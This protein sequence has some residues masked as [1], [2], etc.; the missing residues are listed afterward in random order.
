M[1]VCVIERVGEREAV[2]TAVESS[3]LILTDLFLMRPSSHAVSMV[4]SLND[5]VSSSC[6][7]KPHGVKS[8]VVKS[9]G[10]KPHGVNSHSVKSRRV[11]PHVVKSRGFKSHGVKPRGVKSH[12]VKSRGV[13]S[14]G[15]RPHGVS[16]L[17]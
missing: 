4:F 12:G 1:C 5:F 6:R 10:V 9:H 3:I 8:R 17:S 14:H 11:K 16:P 7:V 13:K 15:V 2:T